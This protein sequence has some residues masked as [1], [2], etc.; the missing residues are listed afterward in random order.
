MLITFTFLALPEIKI[1]NKNSGSIVWRESYMQSQLTPNP[2]A[3]NLAAHLPYH[4]WPY[5]KI[6]NEDPFLLLI[7]K[8][9]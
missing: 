8:M 4:N 1:Q 9:Y 6:R 3:T 5:V 7:M 2:A